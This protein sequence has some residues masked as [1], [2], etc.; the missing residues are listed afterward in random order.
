MLPCP[1]EVSQVLED[2]AQVVYSA[3]QI[4]VVEIQAFKY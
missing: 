4:R 1:L 2:S 3:T